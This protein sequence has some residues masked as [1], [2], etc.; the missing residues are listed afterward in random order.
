MP[1]SLSS[2]GGVSRNKN[3]AGYVAKYRLGEALCGEDDGSS[4]GA[5]L[6]VNID[7]TSL[8]PFTTVQNVEEHSRPSALQFRKSLHGL[9]AS[10]NR[11]TERV[12]LNRL[13]ARWLSWKTRLSM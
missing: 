1:T 10:L 11:K 6:D 13:Q 7:S 8:L 5:L 9:F 4:F 12:I 3:I 2:R